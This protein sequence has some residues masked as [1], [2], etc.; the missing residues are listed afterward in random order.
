[1]EYVVHLPVEIFQRCIAAIELY[2]QYVATKSTI[3]WLV[4]PEDLSLPHLHQQ[5]RPD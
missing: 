3:L 2:L 1:M 5:M 4:I